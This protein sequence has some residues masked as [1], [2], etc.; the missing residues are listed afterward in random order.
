VIEYEESGTRRDLHI[1]E[2][3]VSKEGQ[4][5]I[6]QETLLEILLVVLKA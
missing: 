4:G 5:L 2:C 3:T 6:S 1:S